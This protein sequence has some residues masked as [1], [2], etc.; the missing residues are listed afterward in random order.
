MN[1]ILVPF[2]VFCMTQRIFL[3]SLRAS[4]F[5]R[6]KERE[7][8]SS[9]LLEVGQVKGS[10]LL[11]SPPLPSPILVVVVELAELATCFRPGKSTLT[12]P[13]IR[14]VGKKLSLLFLDPLLS[15]L[16]PREGK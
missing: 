13:G 11:F 5:F 12:Y 9:K 7:K 10:V 8:K 6:G 16:P 3:F 2:F 15:V 4:E 14:G 1:G